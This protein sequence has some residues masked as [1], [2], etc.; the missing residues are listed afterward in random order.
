MTCIESVHHVVLSAVAS[1]EVVRTYGVSLQTDTE[2]LSLQARLHVWQ[3][4]CQNLIKRVFQ[5]LAIA[6]LLYGDILGTIVY[7]DVHDTWVVLELTH[8]VCDTAAT[9]G[10]LNPELADS[11][12]RI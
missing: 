5:D 10:V 4:L 8:G 9:L 1:V 12:V 2:E 11:W 3:L 6:A 7:P